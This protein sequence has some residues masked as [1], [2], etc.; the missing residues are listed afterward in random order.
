[1]ETRFGGSRAEAGVMPGA[2]KHEATEDGDAVTASAQ[3]MEIPAAD[4]RPRSVG[5]RTSH[6]DGLTDLTLFNLQLWSLLLVE[7]IVGA[8]TRGERQ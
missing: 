5:R 3:E 7:R 4:A 8:G 1:M 6:G 2:A